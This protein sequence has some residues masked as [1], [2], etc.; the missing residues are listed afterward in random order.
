MTANNEADSDKV[1]PDDP[2]L[3]SAVEEYASALESGH[4]L[5]RKKFLARHEEIQVALAD[6]LD[7]LELIRTAK[8]H[9]D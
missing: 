6:C 3:I 9:F 4:S 5:D 8:P 1:A 7:A 2:R